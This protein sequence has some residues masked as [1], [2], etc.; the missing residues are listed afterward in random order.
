MCGWAVA[1]PSKSQIFHTKWVFKTK[2]NADGAIE[3]FKAR[4]VACGSEQISSGDYGLT[5]A[6]VLE[7]STIKLILVF[8]LRWGG[9][10][11][12]DLVISSARISK[13]KRKNAWTLIWK[14]PKVWRYRKKS[15]ASLEWIQ[16]VSWHFS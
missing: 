4:L 6:A 10:Y 16:R 15:S 11:W 9:G 7:L 5:F 2:K 1:P 12:P 3:R 8:A 14:F 13:K